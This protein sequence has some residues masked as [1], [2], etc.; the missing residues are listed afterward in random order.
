MIQIEV[1]VMLEKT[2]TFVNLFRG[3]GLMLRTRPDQF[4]GPYQGCIP[5]SKLSESFDYFGSKYLE[6]GTVS[7]AFSS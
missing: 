5:E 3:C 7:A 2:T 1:K 6:L 4:T